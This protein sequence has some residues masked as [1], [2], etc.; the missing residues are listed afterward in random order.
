M[1]FSQNFRTSSSTNFKFRTATASAMAA[2]LLVAGVIG[3]VRV[4]HAQTTLSGLTSVVVTNSPYGRWEQSMAAF[5]AS[6]KQSPPANDGVLFVGSSTIR[7]WTNLAQDFRDQPV[8]INRGFG[9]S[10]LNECGLFA[11]DLVVRYKPRHV[12]V[13]AGDNDLAEGRSPQ[14]VLESFEML[15]KT[16]RAELPNTRIS[17][18]SIKPSPLRVSLL[19]K[20]REANSLISEYVKSM[21]NANYI[22]IFTP[23][24][25]ADGSTR[26]ELF[27]GDMLHMNDEGYKLWH[28]IIAASL[29]PSVVPASVLAQ[30]TPTP[31]PSPQVTAAL[32]A[33]AIAVK[34]VPVTL[35]TPNTIAKPVQLASPAPVSQTVP[36]R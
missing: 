6:D 31:A 13:Y 22:D 32:A 8:V 35:R 23:M 25:T 24:L 2:A 27:R 7:F 20:I 36:A 29:P 30:A 21:P 18:I 5:A 3:G 34:A 26:A 12:L 33:N 4:A 15:A 10:T 11:K 19:P 1:D 28:S 14:Q 9:G 16:V 17:Y